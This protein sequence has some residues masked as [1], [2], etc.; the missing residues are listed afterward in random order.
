MRGGSEVLVGRT[1]RVTCALGES[2]FRPLMVVTKA[3]ST[4]H[5]GSYVGFCFLVELRKIVSIFKAV[6]RTESAREEAVNR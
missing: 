5:I 2:T 4:L 1:R 6:K 3:S